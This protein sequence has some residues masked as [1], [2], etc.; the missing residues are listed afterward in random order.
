MREAYSTSA[1]TYLVDQPFRALPGRFAHLADGDPVA[2]PA[3]RRP[4]GE[5]V[6]FVR[7]AGQALLW[8]SDGE[9]DLKFI[10]GSDP[11]LVALPPDADVP[12]TR[13]AYRTKSLTVLSASDVAQDAALIVLF[14]ARLLL[15][16]LPDLSG[17]YLAYLRARDADAPSEVLDACLMSAA[18]ELF[19][20]L[21]ADLR[22]DGDDH[23]WF[24]AA[25]FS[26]VEEWDHAAAVPISEL[27]ADRATFADYLDGSLRLPLALPPLPGQP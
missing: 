5:K 16:R 14:A 13:M 19:F 1:F 10:P 24:Y 15:A 9:A 11:A 8:L 12:G 26:E 22:I 27:L 23:R 18:D 4:Y 2:K 6:G 7:L 25:R 17:A 21:S 20:A 3:E